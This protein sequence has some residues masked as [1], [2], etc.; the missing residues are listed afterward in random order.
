[1]HF[2]CKTLVVLPLCLCKTS[3][4]WKRI[5]N[6]RIRPAAWRHIWFGQ[7]S[8]V[9]TCSKAR[10]KF[11]V[12]IWLCKSAM[13]KTSEYSKALSRKTTC[14]C[15]SSI[16]R[17]YQLPRLSNVWKDAHQ[18]FFRQNIRIWRSDIGDDTFGQ[19][20]MECGQPAISPTRW[21]KPILNIIVK[22]QTAR[23]T[24]SFL[25]RTFSPS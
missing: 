10:L 22:S 25:I 23:M 4:R 24:I 5:G 14:I 2:Q 21:F 17:N 20:V 3:G 19:S 9:I 16:R 1:M 8:I 15:T 11:G 12:E 13:P 7:Q 18:E 6:H